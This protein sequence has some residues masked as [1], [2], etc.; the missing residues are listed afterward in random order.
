MTETRRTRYALLEREGVINRRCR[1]GVVKSW[2]HSSFF[3]E[4]WM[5]STSW[6]VSNQGA[7][8]GQG[9]L[10]TKDLDAI[11]RRFLLEVALCG[12]HIEQVYRSHAP[13]DLCDCHKPRSDLLLRAQI[14]HRFAFEDAFL[15]DDSPAG[16]RAAETI[17]CPATLVR[18]EAFLQSRS[19]RE[20]LPIVACSFYEAAELILTALELH[21]P[22]HAPTRQEGDST[23]PTAH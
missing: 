9:L 18:R 19:D 5:L 8:V 22:E 14:E 16:L 17:A 20:G 15:V 2:E 11:T 13:A 1:C 23:W 4:R 12:R 10:A 3:R 21:Q 7:A 6:L